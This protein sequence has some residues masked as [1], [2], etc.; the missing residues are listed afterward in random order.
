MKL[1]ASFRVIHNLRICIQT[2]APLAFSFYLSLITN[3]ARPRQRWIS[4]ALLTT[5]QLEFKED[6]I[7]VEMVWSFLCIMSFNFYIL[8]I[9]VST[10]P[11]LCTILR[12]K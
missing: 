3:Q 5:A 12:E 4:D 10:Q 9:F 11:M 1:L 2:S 8:H 7:H 6:C